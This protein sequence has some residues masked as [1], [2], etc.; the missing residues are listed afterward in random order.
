MDNGELLPIALS[1]NKGKHP[2]AMSL[3]Q[4]PIAMGGSRVFVEEGLTWFVCS[5]SQT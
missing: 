3:Y 1:T 5:I 4:E 2:L